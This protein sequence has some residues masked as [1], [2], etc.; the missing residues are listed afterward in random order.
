[1]AVG[2][3]VAIGGGNR[4]PQGAPTDV[5]PGLARGDAPGG[6]PVDAARPTLRS[7]FHLDDVPARALAFDAAG[8][9]V[10]AD[11]RGLVH[12]RACAVATR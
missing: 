7:L 12:A 10:A 3:L 8:E 4:D 9:V 2:L 6:P 5:G 11:D 1:V